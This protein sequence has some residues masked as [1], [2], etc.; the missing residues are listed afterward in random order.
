MIDQVIQYYLEHQEEVD[1]VSLSP[2]WPEGFGVEV[3]SFAVLEQAWHEAKKL[4]EREHVTPYVYLSGKFRSYRLPCPQDLSHL[5][6]TVDEPDDYEVIRQVY[7]ELYPKHGHSFGLSDILDLFQ[8]RPDLFEPNR[9]ILRNNGF[10][11]SI[12]AERR[13]LRYSPKPMLKK[14]EKMWRRAESLITASTQV[15]RDGLTHHIEGVAPKLLAKGKGSRVWDMDGNEYIYYSM[16]H[17]SVILGHSYPRVNKAVRKQLNQ[18]T[19][20]SLM[21][22]LEGEL[23]ELLT[24]IV[25]WAEMVRFGTRGYDAYSGAVLSARAYTGREKIFHCGNYGRDDG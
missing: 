1:Y 20:F 5:R 13:V 18:G 22:P 16:G 17:G 9:H 10:I 15:R 4:Y 3:L 11:K 7:E 24:S 23:A 2:Q 8:R 12:R 21:H 6:L 25:P 14:T 19:N